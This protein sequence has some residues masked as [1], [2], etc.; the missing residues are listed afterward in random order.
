MDR[1]I[2]TTIKD[3]DLVQERRQRLVRAA[4]KV[5]TR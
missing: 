5:F 2:A 4:L 3:R 1:S